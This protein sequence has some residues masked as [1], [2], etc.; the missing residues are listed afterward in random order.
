MKKKNIK[1]ELQVVKVEVCKMIAD[2][3]YK[4]DDSQY[5]QGEGNGTSDLPTYS[6]DNLGR[7]V[8]RSRGAWEEW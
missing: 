4:G 6:D 7:E 3:I 8:V 5:G 1:P 2:S